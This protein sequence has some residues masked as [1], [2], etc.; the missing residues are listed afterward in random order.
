MH[1]QE[2]GLVVKIG[3]EFEFML[4]ERH[5]LLRNTIRP[6]SSHALLAQNTQ[7]TARRFTVGY[8][9]VRIFVTKLIERE[10]DQAGDLQR[11][12]SEFCGIDRLD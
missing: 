9:F 12:P 6:A 4:Y 1:G 5:D 8:Q 3:N 10:I 7:I 2:V 11:L